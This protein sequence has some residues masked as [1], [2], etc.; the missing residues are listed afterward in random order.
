MRHAGSCRRERGFESHKTTVLL[1]EETQDFEDDE[2]KELTAPGEGEGKDDLDQSA[3]LPPALLATVGV[4]GEGG[5]EEL[6]VGAV[7]GIVAY[8]TLDEESPGRGE[9]EGLGSQQQGCFEDECE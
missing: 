9:E 8:E 7:G 1:A 6:L 4:C 2:L 5:E 3:A